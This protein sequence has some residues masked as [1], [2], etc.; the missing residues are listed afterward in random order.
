MIKKRRPYIWYTFRFNPVSLYPYSVQMF[1]LSVS[2]S[3]SFFPSTHSVYSLHEQY[4]LLNCSHS[5]ALAEA[6]SESALGGT[7]Y[8]S[9]LL[10]LQMFASNDSENLRNSLSFCN[11][12][13]CSFYVGKA[14]FNKF[15]DGLHFN[16]KWNMCACVCQ[17]L[18]R[19]CLSWSIL[20]YPNL[21]LCTLGMCSS[22]KGG[23]IREIIKTVMYLFIR[24][25]IA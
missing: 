6:V 14:A 2:L 25:F 7:S 23:K 4:N 22:N 8:G 21:L 3:F 20:C 13:D 24:V 12:C 10:A 18:W 17:S 9:A 1:S 5:D 11:R 16:Q 15:K 19:L